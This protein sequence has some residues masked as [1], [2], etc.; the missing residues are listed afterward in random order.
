MNSKIHFLRR[1]IA[2][3]Q[4]DKIY[5]SINQNVVEIL[6]TKNIFAEKKFRKFF[7]KNFAEKSGCRN[8]R[9]RKSPVAEKSGCGNGFADMSGCGSGFAETTVAE[10]SFAEKSLRI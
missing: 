8:V 9:L 3:I 7:K 5:A 10:K 2:K 6:D 1:K 4:S